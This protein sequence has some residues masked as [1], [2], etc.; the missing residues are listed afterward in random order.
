MTGDRQRE[1]EL[2]AELTLAKADLSMTREI[3][4]VHTELKTIPPLIDKKIRDYDDRQIR[5][6]RWVINTIIASVGL[7]MTAIGLIAARWFV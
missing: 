7:A 6:R 1:L 3:G 4:K 2:V 5:R